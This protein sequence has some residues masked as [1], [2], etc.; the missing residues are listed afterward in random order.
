MFLHSLHFYLN[1][2]S[3]YFYDKTKWGFGIVLT[4][5]INLERTN[6]FTILRLI[7]E[8]IWFSI[9]FSVIS[10]SNVLY[11]LV[12]R[13]ACIF[14]TESKNILNVDVMKVSI[15]IS[16]YVFLVGEI[17]LICVLWILYHC[18]KDFVIFLQRVLGFVIVQS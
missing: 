16:N 4:L 18:L 13:S 5:Y 17:Q 7:Q 10:F 8:H 1:F 9:Y 3:A 12:D 15:S 14:L 6:I 2:R 11:C